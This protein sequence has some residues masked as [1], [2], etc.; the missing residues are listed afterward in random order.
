MMRLVAPS[1]PQIG[2]AGPAGEGIAPP[3]ARAPRS[4]PPSAPLPYAT[5]SRRDRPGV[6][7]SWSSARLGRCI[8]NPLDPDRLF[9]MGTVRG[10]CRQ[11]ATLSDQVVSAAQRLHEFGMAREVA[12]KYSRQS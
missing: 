8:P 5:N 1:G 7:L 12:R 2:S 10:Q 11:R 6:S 4:A 9:L 3:A